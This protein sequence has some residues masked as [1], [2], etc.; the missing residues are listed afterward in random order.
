MI[1]EPESDEQCLV[2]ER[3]ED[4]PACIE[5]YGQHIRSKNDT[6]RAIC[7]ALMPKV[8][9]YPRQQRS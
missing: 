2:D 4:R 1:D 7:P 5:S 8:R 6:V 9:L 3:Q